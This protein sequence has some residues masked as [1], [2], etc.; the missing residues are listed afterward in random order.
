MKKNQRSLFLILTALTA[1]ATPIESLYAA[2]T[3]ITSNTSAITISQTPQNT[4][5]IPGSYFIDVSYDQVAG[6]YTGFKS[7]TMAISDYNTTTGTTP[8]RK[9]TAVFTTTSGTFNNGDLLS[10]STASPNP[11]TGVTTFTAVTVYTTTSPTTSPTILTYTAPL[12]SLTATLTINF[13]STVAVGAARN[14]NLIL[15]ST[16]N[17]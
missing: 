9:V 4:L 16:D 1:F 14:G 13:S 5:S 12:T 11:T 10:L 6:K 3:P 17:I 7:G 8:T 2:G 15:T